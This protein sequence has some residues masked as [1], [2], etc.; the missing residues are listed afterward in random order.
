MY[1][2]VI[3]SIRYG[4]HMSLVFWN[5]PGH[6]LLTVHVYVYLSVVLVSHVT[7]IYCLILCSWSINYRNYLDNP[8]VPNR[9]PCKHKTK[10]IK[11]PI[12]LVRVTCEIISISDTRLFWKT[13]L[14]P[15]LNWKLTNMP[16][17]VVYTAV[18]LL[19]KNILLD[20]RIARQMCLKWK[21]INRDPF[22]VPTKCTTHLL[23]CALRLLRPISKRSA[24][25]C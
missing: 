8:G 15:R 10:T 23:K 17:H 22:L 14:T 12:R 19:D 3:I 21:F 25:K 13:R 9:L 11:S 1:V 24:F 16:K 7:I 4:W 6:G 2:Y 5:Q 18:F 20:T